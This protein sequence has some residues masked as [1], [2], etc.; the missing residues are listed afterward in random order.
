MRPSPRLVLLVFLITQ[1]CDG[2]LTY[3]AVA[4]LGVVEEGNLLLATAMHVA[5]AGPALF[6]AKMIAAACGLLLYAR[7]L[8]LVL[9][10]L[11]GFYMLAAITPWL[12]VFHYL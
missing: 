6:G 5:G 12:F 1:I 8:Y 11:T 3:A 10:V 9:G 7:G 2:L 4:V